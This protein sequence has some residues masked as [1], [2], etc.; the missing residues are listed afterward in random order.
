MDEKDLSKPAAAASAS[1]VHADVI[2]AAEE[3][4][5]FLPN[6]LQGSSLQ[7]IIGRPHKNERHCWRNRT[8]RLALLVLVVLILGTACLASPV[9]VAI[10]A[11]SYWYNHGKHDVPCPWYMH[12]ALCNWPRLYGG[13]SGALPA[14]NI[15]EGNMLWQD[16][17]DPNV[18]EAMSE[19]VKA[20]RHAQP[21]E[22]EKDL[23]NFIELWL[24]RLGLNGLIDLL[25]GLEMIREGNE[26]VVW[27]VDLDDMREELVEISEN[28]KHDLGAYVIARL[29][30]HP[31]ANRTKYVNDAVEVAG[32]LKLTG[33]PL[34]AITWMEMTTFLRSKGWKDANG[35]WDFALSKV[36][37]LFKELPGLFVHCIHGVGHGAMASG[38]LLAMEPGERAKYEKMDVCPKIRHGTTGRAMTQKMLDIALAICRDAPDKQLGYV[39]AGGVFMEYWKST[40]GD[41]T[42]KYDGQAVSREPDVV[43]ELGWSNN[44]D[45]VADPPDEV[46]SFEHTCLYSDF[47]ATCFRFEPGLGVETQ[48]NSLNDL[49]DISI[50]EPCTQSSWSSKVTFDPKHLR[51][52]IL[53]R[54]FHLYRDF[55]FWRHG[56]YAMKKGHL[57]LGQLE[58]LFTLAEWCSM[59]EPQGAS[60]FANKT[61]TLKL[62]FPTNPMLRTYGNWLACIAGSMAS[63]AFVVEEE[64]IE[65]GIV[66]DHCEQILDQRGLRLCIDIGLSRHLRSLPE[67]RIWPNEILEQEDVQPT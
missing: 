57:G 14:L 5:P 65:D 20:L 3:D 55:D 21:Q 48:R 28:W 30:Y 39:C 52:C 9:V 18:Q 38:V 37:V 44:H 46:W 51:G 63:V 33:G 43:V 59:Y 10:L 17:K 61:T 60:H 53:G 45:R 6:F 66:E 32:S 42:P 67:M 49:E 13:S 56:R 24:P 12:D 36:C 19:A 64:G 27:D 4:L 62:K 26:G 31:V 7:T 47:P 22:F 23:C 8:C 2:G 15:S 25:L 58:R 29:Q 16:P 11:L 54:S 50:Y 35:L 40:G 1:D 34:H 41:W